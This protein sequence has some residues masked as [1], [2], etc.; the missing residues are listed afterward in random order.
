MN[1]S[2]FYIS[3]IVDF[4]FRDET[5]GGTMNHVAMITRFWSLSEIQELFYKS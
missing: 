4:N 1:E 5:C 3:E 2:N